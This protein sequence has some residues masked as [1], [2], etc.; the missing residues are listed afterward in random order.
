[1]GVRFLLVP[2]A[3]L[4]RTSHQNSSA[5]CTPSAG[6]KQP[7]AISPLKWV[8]P[9][10]RPGMRPAYTRE[11]KMEPRICK[12]T[13]GELDAVSAAVKA[14]WGCWCMHVTAHHW[15]GFMLSC[16]SGALGIWVIL[17]YVVHSYLQLTNHAGMP[18]QSQLGCVSTCV[19]PSNLVRKLL[20]S[21]RD[22]TCMTMYSSPFHHFMCPVHI[23]AKLTA[24][25]R[26]APEMLANV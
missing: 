6:P 8:A 19:L 21:A 20:L 26:C 5:L 1:M 13:A 23:S 16:S 17:C 2:R 22:P 24:G 10:R 11:P 9:M 3:Q 7:G 15:H 18:L 25:L 4:A 14:G 12:D